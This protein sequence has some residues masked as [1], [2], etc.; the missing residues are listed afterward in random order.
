MQRLDAGGELVLGGRG[1]LG[2]LAAFV[3]L[4]VL[5]VLPFLAADGATSRGAW[6]A[7]ASRAAAGS[8]V[9]SAEATTTIG[10][11]AY[12]LRANSVLTATA[13]VSGWTETA[14]EV[15]RVSATGSGRALLAP[16]P[17]GLVPL[18]APS[19]LP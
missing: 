16:V 8:F 19:G 2:C 5:V 9:P 4:V 11:D 3:V 14:E 10:A 15:T 6:I 17:A 18:P 13:P 7:R 12:S 1:Y